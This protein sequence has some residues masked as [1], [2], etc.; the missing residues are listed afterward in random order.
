MWDAHSATGIVIGLALFVL[1]ATGALLL[2]RGEIRQWEEPSV[3]VSTAASNS[4]ES[5]PSL[6]ALTRPVLDSLGKGGAVPSYVYMTL[7][8]DG[9]GNLYMHVSGG[10][11]GGSRNTWIHP[12]TGAWVANPDEGAVTQTLYYLHFFF[13]FGRWGLYLAGLIGLFGFLAV[14][15]GTLV[16][17]HRI[18]KDFFQFRPGTKLRVAWADAHKVLGTIGLPFQ[19]MY[20]FTGAY[21]G[22]VGL[23]ALPYASILFDGSMATYYQKAGYYAPPV[24]MDSVQTAD[25]RPALAGLV[26]RADRQWT[27]FEPETVVA[28][29][30]GTPTGRVEVI[31]ATRGA[32]FGGTGAV[33]FHGQTGE[34]LLT[35]SPQNAGA[36]NEAVQSMEMLHFATFGGMALK[37][38]FFLLAVASC[39]VILTGN[40][41]WLEIRRTQD[42]AVVTVL[43]RLTAGVATGLL[44][45]TALLFLADRWVP[46]AVGS[47]DWWADM[48]LF[49]SWGLAVCY[50]LARRN[51][52][53]THRS[54]L[55]AGGVLALLLPLANGLTTGDW[56]WVA[57]SAGQWAVLGVDIGAVLCGG[58][59]LGTA[60]CLTVDAT[61]SATESSV[62][63]TGD[64][65]S[66]PQPDTIDAVS[67]R[68]PVQP[69]VSDEYAQ[70]S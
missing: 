26:A 40:L 33:V 22:L 32:V 12:Q 11:V 47:P 18:V 54:L 50:A 17:L 68:E 29:G 57:W 46:A 35:E 13:Q 44:P 23:I 36:L 55:V 52:A 14:T 43:S 4:T 58:A 48:V 1:F 6:D 39:A 7:P 61:P 63:R 20:V 65:R 27:D 21:L 56:L 64:T 41:T 8:E 2:F 70:D 31:G 42:R 49:G 3:R 60:A 15:T 59:A 51:V 9:H 45:A 16:H 66:I 62:V 37:V 69:P 30:L 38:L 5:R 10:V 67:E 34:M 53:R 28:T 19:T 24:E 25:G